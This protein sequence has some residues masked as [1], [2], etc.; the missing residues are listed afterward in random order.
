M[1]AIFPQIAKIFTAV[2]VVAVRHFYYVA[3][4][5]VY[6]IFFAIVSVFFCVGAK[7]LLI[8]TVKFAAASA[9]NSIPTTLETIKTRDVYFSPFF[10]FYFIF[11]LYTCNIY[12]RV[13]NY[14]GESYPRRPAVNVAVE[15]M[16]RKRNQ[17]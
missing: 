9:P 15:K 4:S 8:A 7:T 3:V 2:I 6:F 1:S 17:N 12:K 10:H 16:D 5:L 14:A 11:T 13:Y